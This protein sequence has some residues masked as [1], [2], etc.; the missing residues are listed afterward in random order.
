MSEPRLV[1]YTTNYTNRTTTIATLAVIAAGIVL[2]VAGSVNAGEHFVT[3]NNKL[4]VS[5]IGV[6]SPIAV[7]GIVY[8]VYDNLIWRV[9]K[10][11]SKIPSLRGEWTGQ[12]TFDNRHNVDPMECRVTI[13]QTWSKMNVIFRGYKDG[14]VQTYSSIIM[15][16]LNKEENPGGLRYEYQVRPQS[17]AAQ[18]PPTIGTAY[19]NKAPDDPN[20]L[21]G[22]Y[23]NAP[24]EVD[25]RNR[26]QHYGSYVIDKNAS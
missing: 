15:A 22:G 8:W 12:V 24:P 4:L 16:A 18:Q 1:P 6:P 2:V 20:H 14:K 21:F 19:L 13:T 7:F 25:S 10:V 9:P 5:L 17:G 26:L 3:K 23:Y 11:G